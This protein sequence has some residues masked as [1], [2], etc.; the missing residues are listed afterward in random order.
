L[1]K[2]SFLVKN[3][4]IWSSLVKDGQRTWSKNMVKKHGQFTVAVIDALVASWA[5]AEQKPTITES[6]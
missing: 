6:V 1:K 4:Q 3:G 5:I 2:I